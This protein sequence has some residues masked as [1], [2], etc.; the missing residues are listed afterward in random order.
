MANIPVDVEVLLIS[1][2][3]AL[4]KSYANPNSIVGEALSLVSDMPFVNQLKTRYGLMQGNLG[5]MSGTLINTVGTMIYRPHT[6]ISG[7]V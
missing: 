3:Q 1:L 2:I 7:A 6:T 5:Q 4:A